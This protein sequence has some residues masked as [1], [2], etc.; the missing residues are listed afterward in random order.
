M[1]R[2]RKVAVSASAFACFATC[3]LLSSLA[4]GETL[5]PRQHHEWGRFPVGSWKKV[6]LVTEKLDRTGQVISSNISV[7]TTTVVAV[8]RVAVE[9]RLETVVEVAGKQFPKERYL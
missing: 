4:F 3:I 5:I 6:R 7:T 1:I 9:L 2:Q 8:H